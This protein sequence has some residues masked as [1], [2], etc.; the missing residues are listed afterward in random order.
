MRTN[1]KIMPAAALIALVLTLH[2]ITVASAA[3]G[4]VFLG[5][6]AF[7]VRLADGRLS[8][9][10]LE[11]VQ[12]KDGPV[13]P[14]AEA[15]IEEGD[16]IIAVNGEK[17]TNAA[18]FTDKIAGSKGGEVTLTIRRGTEQ[19]KV[20]VTPAKS[21]ESGDYRLGLWVRDSTAGIGT[22]TF[23]VPDT[24]AFGA[25]GHGIGCPE[26]EGDTKASGA[27]YDVTIDTVKRGESGSPGELCGT[28]GSEKTGSV[29]INCPE[30]LFGV[31]SDVPGVPHGATPLEIC[32][33]NEVKSGGAKLYCT[34]GDDGVIAYDVTISDVSDEKD[35]P[36]SFTVTANDPKLL[37]RTGGIVQ[38]MSGSPL[39]QNGRLIGAVTHVL[40]SDPTRGY[41]IFIENM[42]DE[43]P[44][45]LRG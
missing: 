1:R 4:E 12:T 2:M 18:E 32:P 30:G 11:D 10:S 37:E 21:A 40:I 19:K 9:V 31:C 44:E 5:G 42:L 34:L 25:L 6:S 22:M 23:V 3:E 43:L 35:A 27:L 45:I 16:E 17:V 8:A 33:F 26:N 38:G 7:G 39:V 14:A 36:R 13:C 29:L 41:G 24:L 28:F 15:G 20:T